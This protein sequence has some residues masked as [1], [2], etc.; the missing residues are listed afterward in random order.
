MSLI[1]K[2]GLYSIVIL[3]TMGALAIEPSPAMN[4][5]PYLSKLLDRAPELFTAVII[6]WLV[7][8]FLEHTHAKVSTALNNLTEAT[9]SLEEFLRVKLD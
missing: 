4:T 6:L 3:G 5:I 2:L 7:F 8:R 9:R 1:L